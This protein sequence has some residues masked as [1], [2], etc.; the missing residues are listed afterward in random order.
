MKAKATRQTAIEIACPEC[1]GPYEARNGSQYHAL[2]ELRPNQK[3]TCDCGHTFGLPAKIK[4]ILEA[5]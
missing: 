2:A 4:K 3:F 1:L 5:R